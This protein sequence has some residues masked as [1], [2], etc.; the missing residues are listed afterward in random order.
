MKTFLLTIAL[1]VVVAGA[2]LAVDCSFDVYTGTS[3]ISFP[4]VPLNSDPIQIFTNS[5]LM[6]WNYTLD[7]F[8]ATTESAKTLDVWADVDPAFGGILLGT[9]YTIY[10]DA[11]YTVS[12]A[13]LPSGVPDG[14]GNITD[15]WISLPGNQIDN[16]DEGGW[17]LIG[18][19][20]GDAVAIDPNYN[21]NGEGI[22]FTDGV[23]VK[24][25]GEAS[26]NSAGT[27]WVASAASYIDPS[28]G[29][30]N[31]TGFLFLDDDHFRPGVGY[32]IK[33]FKDNLAMIIPAASVGL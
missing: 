21:V 4:N 19:P 15:M 28:T 33:T 3:W 6:P 25:W 23:T 13:G 17:N 22:L 32:M 1:L 9:G 11:D 5:N 2:S 14:S 10:A 27:P 7:S 29:Q 24:T 18:T 31:A 30:V 20:Y 12:F 16:K 8:D 26:D